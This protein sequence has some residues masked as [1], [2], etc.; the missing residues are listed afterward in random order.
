M[1]AWKPSDDS[2]WWSRIHRVQPASQSDPVPHPDAAVPAG[3]GF[4]GRPAPADVET[5]AARGDGGGA[6]GADG[7][8]GGG[9]GTLA[10]RSALYGGTE[11]ERGDPAE[12][13][14][15]SLRPNTLKEKEDSLGYFWTFKAGIELTA[16]LISKGNAEI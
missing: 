8:D 6:G 7:G 4:A 5:R 10:A 13:K 16:F 1:L 2:P 14:G 15:R 12:E 3:P 9:S 11:M